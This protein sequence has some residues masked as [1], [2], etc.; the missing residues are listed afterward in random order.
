MV[1][2]LRVRLSFSAFLVMLIAIALLATSALLAKRAKA[3][4]KAAE[5]FS[6]AGVA[7]KGRRGIS[8]GTFGS[9]KA[10]PKDPTQYTEHP[11][12]PRWTEAVPPTMLNEL[13]DA[14]FDFIRIPIDP[15]PL[16]SADETQ[17]QSRILQ[18]TE[19][20]DHALAAGLNVI[21]DVHP[22]QV[23][24]QWNFRTLT[25]GPGKPAFQRLLIV[26]RALAAALTKFDERRVALEVFN[27]P[28]PPCDWGD[29]V[30]WPDQ[31]EILTKEIRTVASRI[32]LL[33]AG[34]CWASSEG[35][36]RLRV[37]KFDQNTIFV[38]HFYY[39]W[40]F[41]FQG[42][43]SAQSYVKY[44]QRLKFPPDLSQ[45]DQMIES[46]VERIR[47]DKDLSK[48]Q[49]I[50]I[51]SEARKYLEE[52]FSEFRGVDS[53]N[54]SFDEINRWA[55]QN[56]IDPSRIVIGEFGVLG[57]VYGFVSAATEDR[58]RWIEAVRMAAEKRGFRWAVWQYSY[59]FGIIEG[60]REGPLNPALLKALGLKPS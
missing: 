45:K 57:D 51:I 12:A 19:A 24:R 14:G 42:F 5:N 34:A 47:A 23:H 22:S 56:K 10:D 50:K 58:A 11:Y 52:Y 49:Q 29:R 26:A 43:W 37:S 36:R 1:H 25:A 16:L 30:S 31:L 38:I 35:L 33:L 4:E 13:A 2:T 48:E 41:T 53:I 21:V 60:D 20:V 17:L 44:I 59:S 3:T 9:P 15:G 28:P 55:S 40:V 8:I 54:R 39:P 6:D 27:E 18:I 7:F 46:V 32:T